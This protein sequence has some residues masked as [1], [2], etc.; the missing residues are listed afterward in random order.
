ME[1]GSIIFLESLGQAAKPFR[2]YVEAANNIRKLFRENPQWASE[3]KGSVRQYQRYFPD[4]PYL[5]EWVK[6]I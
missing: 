4:D 2:E 3:N 6:M 1:A 5:R